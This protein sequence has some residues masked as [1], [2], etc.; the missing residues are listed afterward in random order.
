MSW[1][2]TGKA[3]T[4]ANYPEAYGICDRCGFLFNLNPDL[5]YQ[6]DYRGPQLVN[7]RLRVCP[8][9]MDKPTIWFRPLVYPADPV[10]VA[11][12]RLPDYVAANQGTYPLPPLPWPAVPIG[13]QPTQYLSSDTGVGLTGD[14][15]TPLTPD[16][17]YAL[18]PSDPA[19][20][21]IGGNPPPPLDVGALFS[22]P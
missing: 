14:T 7:L 18:P 6:Y 9:C 3:R 16:N 21:G 19:N 13:P 5:H 10:P 11:D 20:S 8:R 4:D 12:P 17:P 1:R 2:Y 22:E 15:G